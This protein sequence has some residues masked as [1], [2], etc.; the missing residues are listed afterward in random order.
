MAITE[1]K[2][3]RGVTYKVEIRYADKDGKVYCYTKSFHKKSEAVK[4]EREVWV[5]IYNKQE[6]ELSTR[7]FNDVF[8]EY[9]EVKGINKYSHGTYI[10][11]ISKH[12]IYI[13]DT[14]GKK[15]M[16][17]LNYVAIQRYFNSLKDNKLSLNQDIKKVFNITFNYAMQNEYIRSNPMNIGVEVTGTKEVKEIRVISPEELEKLVILLREYPD[18]KDK[19]VYYSYSIALYLGYYL[20]TRISET[21]A[22]EKKDFDFEKNEVNINKRLVGNDTKRGLYVTN[23]MK[24]K[25][26]VAVLPICKPLKVVLIEW[27][28]M[29]PHEI[30]CA[31]EDGSYI[32]YNALDRSV[33]RISQQ[34]GFRFHSHMLRH[35]FATNLSNGNIPI[36]TVSELARHSDC[37]TTLKYYVHSSKDEH[38][39]AISLVFDSVKK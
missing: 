31:R 10:K 6:E 28:E 14:I 19:F 5:K 29:N 38:K 9:M 8:N 30:V 23:K 20:G 27:F 39:K 11:Y 35:S 22:L 7:T 33:N 24:T 4:H 12:R 1:R 3:K 36:K 32:Q 18:S 26:S 13:K 17:E 21:L 2:R 15:K 16:N 25:S 37:R 34:L